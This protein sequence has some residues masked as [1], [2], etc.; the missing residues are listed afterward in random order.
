MIFFVFYVILMFFMGRVLDKFGLWMVL[1]FGGILVGIGWILV[2][3]FNGLIYFILG[4]GIIVG[5][6]VGIVYGVLIVVFVKWFEDKRGFVVGLIVLGFGMLFFIIVFI[7][8]KFIEMYGFFLIF[9]ILGVVFLIVIILLLILLK[10]LFREVII[11]EG[12][13]IKKDKFFYFFFEMVKIKIFWV[14][15]FCFVIGMLSGLMVIGILSFVG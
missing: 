9:R 6:G 13:K 11:D 1:I 10:F 14:F 8:R 12:F 4:Y 5:I 2:G 3:F 7:V 15:W